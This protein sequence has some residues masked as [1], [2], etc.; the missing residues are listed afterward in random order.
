MGAHDEAL[1]QRR[2]FALYLVLNRAE[3]PAL[4]TEYFDNP[5]KGFYQDFTE[6]DMTQAKKLKLVAEY[7]LEEGI[8]DYVT[9]YLEKK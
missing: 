5:F 6:A 2:A 4:G 8:H 7:G 9:N 1:D 3:Q